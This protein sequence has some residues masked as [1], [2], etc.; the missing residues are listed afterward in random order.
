MTPS[1]DGEI[2]TRSS[3]AV[4]GGTASAIIGEWKAPVTGSSIARSPSSSAA[5]L[6]PSKP[7]RSPDSTTCCGE[8]SLATASPCGSASSCGVLGGAPAHQR[9]HAAVAGA[10][11]RLLHQPAA[12]RDQLEPVALAQAAGRDERG[13][14]AERVAGHEIARR[15]P[16]RLP[17]GQAGAEDRGLGE[18]VPSSARGNGSSPTICSA[19]ESSSGRTLATVSR[20]SGVWLP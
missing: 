16:E 14:L 9:E 11:A 17:P 19:S 20:I 6:A 12:Q 13:Q 3:A 2:S 4:N 5:A 1:A 15:S 10:L 7:A 18:R 8:L